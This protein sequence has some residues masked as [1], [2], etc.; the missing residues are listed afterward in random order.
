MREQAQEECA[1]MARALGDEV[2][3]TYGV[4]TGASPEEALVFAASEL[5]GDVLVVPAARGPLARLARRRISRKARCA[6]V[7]AP[8][9]VRR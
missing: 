8:R 1:G 2:S 6:V 9:A 7:E 4:F 5:A 3:A